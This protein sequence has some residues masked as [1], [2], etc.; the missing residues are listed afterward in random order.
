MR[1]PRWFYCAHTSKTMKTSPRI[2]SG[3]WLI[4]CHLRKWERKRALQRYPF[5]SQFAQQL[6]IG[7]QSATMFKAWAGKLPSR[8]QWYHLCFFLEGITAALRPLVKPKIIKKRTKKFIWHQSD[9]YVKIKCNWQKH[10]GIDDRIRR[11]FKGQILMP[12]MGYGSNKKTKHMLP[13]GSQKFL[14]HKSKSLRCC[15]CAMNLTVKRLLTMSP[16]RT[17]KP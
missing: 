2:V 11:R 6:E 1:L 9:Q 17:V 15:W 16:P 5:Y 14:V 10:R 7:R 8:T 4:F 12:N 13:S 3:E